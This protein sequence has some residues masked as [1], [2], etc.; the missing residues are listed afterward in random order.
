MCFSGIR[1]AEGIFS[2]SLLNG[3]RRRVC[4]CDVFVLCVFHTVH[5]SDFVVVGYYYYYL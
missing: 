3:K 1:I 2:R 4:L 5:S